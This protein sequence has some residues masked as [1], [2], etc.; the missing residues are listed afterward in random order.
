MTSPSH[1]DLV[2]WVAVDEL[3]GDVVARLLAGV[4]V[5]VGLPVALGDVRV[6]RWLWETAVEASPE[7]DEFCTN[8]LKSV[9]HDAAEWCEGVGGRRG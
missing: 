2:P 8:G 3:F 6:G 4:Q 1:I 7:I 5:R 9:V